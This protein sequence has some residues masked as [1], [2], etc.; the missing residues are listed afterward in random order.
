MQQRSDTLAAKSLNKS[1]AKELQALQKR[2]IGRK[3][4]L[5]EAS[6]NPIGQKLLEELKSAHERHRNDK[7]LLAW[8]RKMREF[9]SSLQKNLRERDKHQREVEEIK[10]A[11]GNLA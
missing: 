3:R 11:Q 8:H 4:A 1:E 7:Q 9:Q 10:A 2:L 5:L 6:D